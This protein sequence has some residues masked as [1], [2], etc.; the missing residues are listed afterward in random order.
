M[1]GYAKR[2]LFLKLQPME[3]FD[4]HDAKPNEESVL[5]LDGTSLG[6]TL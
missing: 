4:S 2:P 1:R 3:V 6:S 5:L